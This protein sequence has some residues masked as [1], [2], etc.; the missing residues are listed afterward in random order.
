M[1][2]RA[3]LVG[4]LDIETFPTLLVG[5]RDGL[6]FLGA[7]TPQSD[8]LRRLLHSLLQPDAARLAHQPATQRIIDQLA[9]S[10]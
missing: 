5:N 6:N 10:P 4:D 2:D 9:E 1:E 8:V 7:V 3:D